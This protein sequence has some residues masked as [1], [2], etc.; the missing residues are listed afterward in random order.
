MLQQIVESATRT[1]EEKYVTTK[2]NS[3]AIELLRNQRNHV[4]T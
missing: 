1:R 4:A 2:E 3:I